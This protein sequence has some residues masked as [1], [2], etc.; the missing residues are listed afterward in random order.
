MDTDNELFASKLAYRQVQRENEDELREIKQE[1]SEKQ[2]ENLKLDYVISYKRDKLKGYD[3]EISKWD[4]FKNTLI[5]LKEYISAYLPLSPLIEE[6]ANCV[7]HKKDIEAGNSFRGLLNAL[8][9]FLRA[10]KELIVDGVCWFPR[11]MRWETSKGEVA[12]VFSDYKNE[13]YDYRLKAYMNVVT[14]EK[15]SID[16][17]QEEIKPE[18]RIGTLEQLEQGIVAAEEMVQEVER[19]R[20][21]GR[22]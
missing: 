4:Q 17:I 12:P 19:T 10:F 3:D 8:G 14:K 6:F 18:N 11:L 20:V 7:E 5:M 16:S 13:G 15:Y 1:I 2:S 22:E 21:R 9:Q